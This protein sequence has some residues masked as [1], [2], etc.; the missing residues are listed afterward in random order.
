MTQTEAGWTAARVSSALTRPRRRTEA[1]GRAGE[2]IFS[3]HFII[4]SMTQTEAGWKAALPL[5]RSRT[6]PPTNARRITVRV[7]ANK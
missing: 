5:A 7:E 2:G 6:L 3:F 4:R 1:G